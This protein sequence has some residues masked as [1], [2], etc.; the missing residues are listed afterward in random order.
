LRRLR[1]ASGV[2]LLAVQSAWM[3][4]ALVSLD[5]TERAV[6][7]VSRFEALAARPAP[8]PPPPPLALAPPESPRPSPADMFHTTGFGVVA[9]DPTHYVVD[10]RAFRVLLEQG[11]ETMREAH[12]MLEG[13]NGRV[14]GIRLFG[15]WP[16]SVLGSLGFEN[17]DRVE[18]VCGIA[19]SAPE[20]VLAA[21]A[22]LSESPKVTVVVTRRGQ[23]VT[24]TYTIV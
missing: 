11:G 6:S 2:A 18:R 20:L 16:D 9:V 13:K 23:H 17:S 3:A 8:A 5:V 1:I 21:F 24:L 10:R 14:E 12:L 19:L 7:A 22:R 15:V 4:I